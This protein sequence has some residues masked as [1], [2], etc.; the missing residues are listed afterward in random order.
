[1]EEDRQDAIDVL[2]KLTVVKEPVCMEIRLSKPWPGARTIHGDA[3]DG[4][5][6]VI[7]TATPELDAKGNVKSIT[8]ALTNISMQKWAARYQQRRSEEAQ[9]AK[10]AQE[11]FID[12]VSHE[13]RNPLSAIIQSADSILGAE[14]PEAS[15][16]LVFEAADTITLCAQHQKRIIDDILTLSRLDSN[17]ILVTPIESDPIAV[18]S[19]VLKMFALEMESSSIQ[20]ETFIGQGY[21]TLDLERVTLD[22][23]RLIQVLVNLVG[24]ALKFTRTE[25]EPRKIIV[26]IDASLGKPSEPS[27][28]FT[29]LRSG[30]SQQDPTTDAVWGSG[31]PVYLQFIVEDTGKGL[32]DDEKAL[33]FQRYTQANPKTHVEYGGSGL[34][35]FI[36]RELT[37]KQGGAIGVASNAGVGSMFAFYIKA[38][39]VSPSTPPLQLTTDGDFFRSKQANGASVERR[40]TRT[41]PATAPTTAAEKSRPMYCLVVEDNVVNQRVLMKGLRRH[42]WHV[43]VAHH[44]AE[45]LTYLLASRFARHAGATTDLHERCVVLM[46]LEMPV[47]DGLTCVREIRRLE[48]QV[49]LRHVPVIAVTANARAEQISEARAAGM[50]SRCFVFQGWSPEGRTGWQRA[51]DEQDDVVSKPFRI[52]DLLPKMAKQLNTL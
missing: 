51:D 47:M 43:D 32:T 40:S 24:N 36:S 27:S 3:E 19:G 52:I 22:P 31:E 20:L 16:E 5:T 13:M 9:S 26:R 10:R 6:W 7:A 44:G 29:Y 17:L 46:D 30:I 12:M 2:G 18:V 28:G 21:E 49:E 33:L 11:K 15:K 25:K 37:E 48:A 45:A 38:R 41:L 35:L 4:E 50:V 23:S 42:G 1:M 8:G 39:R 14:L 34:G